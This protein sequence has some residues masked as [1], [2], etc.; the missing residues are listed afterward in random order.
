MTVV[1][2]GEKRVARGWAVATFLVTMLA[3]SACSVP[4]PTP[5][6]TDAAPTE[7][8]ASSVSSAPTRRA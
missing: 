3:A 2:M 1:A 4:L 8:S 5:G 6:E 7:P